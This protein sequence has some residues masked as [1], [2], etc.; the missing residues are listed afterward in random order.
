MD[1]G[2]MILTPFVWLLEFFYNFLGSYG[3]ALILFT[4]VVKVILFPL[5]L[6]GKRSMI[7]MN[8]LSG[9]IQK[10]QKKYANNPSKAND[11]VQKLYDREG[12]SP[13]GGC[14]WSMIP[15]FIL[16]PLYAII[17]Q[18]LKYMMG[19]VGPEMDEMLKVIAQ[20]VNWDAL[21]VNSG[22]ITQQ[23]VDD[24]IKAAQEA[25]TAYVTSFTN[26]GYNQLYLSSLITS[27]N[28]EAVK[29]AVAAVGTTTKEIFPIN[30]QFLGINLA[31]VPKPNFWVNGWSW[32]SIGLF[33]IPLVSAA[34]TMAMSLVMNKTN[35]MSG[36]ENEQMARTNRT[37]MLI[38]PIMYLF[39]GFSMPAAL[40]VYLLMSSILGIGQELICGRL[41]KKDYEKAAETK[42]QRELEEKEEEKRQRR[43]KA[44]K[45]AK[46]AEEARKNKAKRKALEAEESAKIPPE[47]REASR[48]GIRQYARGRAYDPNRFGGVTP[49]HEDLAAQAMEKAEEAEQAQAEEKA[50]EEVPA[51]GTAAETVE[52]AAMEAPTQEEG[53]ETQ[54][55]EEP[56]Q[57]T[58]SAEETPAGEDAP[59]EDI[60]EKL[61]EEIDAAV[62]EDETKED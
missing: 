7:Q 62:G 60:V 46:E 51:V 23:V 20:T 31:F 5:S 17:R 24:A 48:V 52:T 21:A 40:S 6:K 1:L 35:N 57:E 19:V 55:Q 38:S 30:F 28:L 13:M 49:Y 34:V 25:G 11:E 22:W 4:L 42:K 26:G 15:L 8:L 47:V 58:A 61:Q 41:L 9:E 59:E 56:G 45:R 33:L 50:A 36:A 39:F 16:I 32:G 2:Y 3:M 29:S 44:E 14:L 27:E 37:M 18:P 53:A 10:I 12:V 43:E 54:P